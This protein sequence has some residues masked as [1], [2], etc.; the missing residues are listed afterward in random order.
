M[1]VLMS[2]RS[3]SWLLKSADLERHGSID[4]GTDALLPPWPQSL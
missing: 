1:S 2:F 3:A 4:D